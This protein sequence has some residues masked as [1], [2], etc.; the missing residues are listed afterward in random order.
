MQQTQQ[1]HH[2]VRVPPFSPAQ[3]K[4]IAIATLRTPNQKK[5]WM[6]TDQSQARTWACFFGTSLEV[7][8]NIW[9]RLAESNKIPKGGAPRHLLYAYAG[10]DANA[11]M[12][13]R[14]DLR[15]IGWNKLVTMASIVYDAT[16]FGCFDKWPFD[17]KMWDVK[18]H[19]AGL[20]YDVASSIHNGYIVH[21]SGWHKG[22]K[23]D[24]KIFREELKS[25]LDAGKC[26]EADAGCSGECCLKNPQVAKS[27]RA[28]QQKGVVR[29]RQECVFCKMKK[30][31]S[32]R[33]IWIHNYDKHTFAVGAVLVSIQI[34]LE[35]GTV[36]FWDIPDYEAEYF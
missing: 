2:V 13:I 27:R 31:Q 16:T 32:L 22:G 20:K 11:K 36:K 6:Y 12:V 28:K 19:K 24:I 26:V 25:K 33:G 23:S 10:D 34:G 9:N 35:L 15:L 18:R 30:F 29:A 4:T 7:A 3:F 17:S 8:S 14:M 5:N 21:W 1:G